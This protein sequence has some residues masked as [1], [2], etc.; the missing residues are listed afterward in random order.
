[1]IE[2]DKKYWLYIYPIAYCCI[3]EKQ[4]ILY[5][6]QSGESIETDNSVI[7]NL[8]KLLHK[9]ENLGTI[10]CEG[11][12]LLQTGILDFI[13]EFC[14]K[15]MGNIADIKQMP[16]KPTQLMPVL[17]LQRDIEKQ[18]DFGTEVLQYL[19]ELNIYPN[20]NCRQGCQYCNEYYR[21]TLCCR[22]AA[23]SETSL[24][25]SVLQNILS[26]IR[27]GVV[28][29]INILG[30]NILLYPDLLKLSNILADFNDRV[31]FYVHYKN[32]KRNVVL[33]NFHTEL[34]VNFPV[35][36]HVLDKVLSEINREK[37]DVHFIIENEEQCTETGQLVENHGIEKYEIKPFF[38]GK[39]I[40]FFYESVFID[41]EDLCSK[42]LSMR[43]IFKNQKLNSNFFGVLHIFQDGSVKAN[44]NTAILG[45]IRMNK[46][47]DLVYKE[48]LENTAWRKIRDSQPCRECLYQFI[49]PAPSNYEIV[50]GKPNLCHINS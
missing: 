14:N 35:D 15:N 5:N 7:L 8:L 50:I 34:I 6:T 11:N 28:G 24:D 49:C 2:I 22:S 12:I 25:V 38:N 26:Q 17:N 3:K 43:E 47:L 29:K 39:N 40:D 30:G 21:Q 46:I 27:F 19:V 33:E 13:V 48:M 44:P 32:Y 20:H 37:A 10:S 23:N 41:K 9:K 31:H 42:T 36:N 1:M 18:E 16:E 45:N 4:A